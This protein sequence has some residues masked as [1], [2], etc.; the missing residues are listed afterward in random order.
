MLK[1]KR[2]KRIFYIMLSILV[3]ALN[4]NV[5]TNTNSVLA[6]TPEEQAASIVAK[7]TLEEK[8]GQMFMPDFRNWNGKGFTVYNDEVGNIIKQYHLGGVILFAENVVGTEQTVRLTD[9]LQNSV[10]G[11]QDSR[12]KIPLLLS[13]DQEGGSIIRL[14]TGTNMP[15]NMAL[16]ATNDPNQAFCSGKVIGEELNSLGINLNFAP[17]LDVNVNPFNPVIGVRSFGGDPQLVAK[18]GVSY[19][20]GLHDGG[21]ASTAKHFPGHGD[22]AT[23][24]HLGLPVVTHNLEQVHSLN[25]VPF[26][27]AINNG[28]DMIMTAHVVFP[29]IDNSQVTS[30]KDGSLVSLP[31]TLSHR[32]LTDLLRTEMGFKGIV[33]TDALNMAAISSNF[34]GEQAVIMAINA[35]ADIVLMPASVTKASDIGNLDK[36]FK[37]VL[38]AVQ[39]GTINESQI[40]ASATRIIALK[41]KR[42]IY[43]PSGNTDTSTI[44]QKVANAL[45]V[46]GSPVHKAIETEASNKAVTLVKN[47][48]NMLPFNLKDNNTVVVISPFTDRNDAMKAGISE[49]IKK[50]NLNNV[51]I[52]TFTYA[53]S[54]LS[55][56]IKQ[57]IDSANYVILGTYG[58]NTASITPGANFYTQFPRNLIA[59]NSSSKNIPLVAVS[60]CA[61]YD[62]MSIPNVGAYISVFG[63]YGNTQNLVS[64]MRATFGLINPTGKLPVD[65][66]DGVE[67]YNNKVNLYNFGFGLSYPVAVNMSVDNSK[68]QRNNTA[69]ISFNASYDSGINVD[70]TKADIQYFSSD[71]E[72][73]TVENGVIT[74]KNTGI[75]EI[76]ASV[77]LDGITTKSNKV[78]VEVF[79]SLESIRKLL[80]GF[81]NTG[82]LEG[83]LVPQLT[84]SLTQVEK[85]INESKKNQAINHLTDFN[86]L[87]NSP[88]MESHIL[89]TAR[90]VLDSD[91]KALIKEW[92]K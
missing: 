39:N 82:A 88:P 44:D 27:A 12:V 83:S 54:T 24:S 34:G 22:T 89:N 63:R 46:V 85:F 30:T 50:R 5:Y 51:T 90:V 70:L 57:A 77:K 37:A 45:S 55:A 56:T 13:I 23:D 47:E 7:M 81:K 91:S 42:G 78:T 43:N 15:G 48:N 68:L 3:I 10:A 65:I 8:V 40:N 17:V 61:P 19:I 58:Y 49:V 75:A 32:V 73:V 36:V 80:E 26:Q 16:G 87:L 76:Y 38:N 21:T 66:P 1:R 92:S 4:L 64:G 9:G 28:V 2:G 84:N 29:A 35:G 86:K 69:N 74:A 59:Y 33:V 11:L 52:K 6:A 79:T 31:A 71:P 62:V 53:N 25:L 18:M 14:A 41:I 60:I 67:G 20:N 72:V